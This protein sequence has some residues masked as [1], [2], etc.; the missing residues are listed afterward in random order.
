MQSF[1][2]E[3][4]PKGQFVICILLKDEVYFVYVRD[5]AR[6]EDRVTSQKIVLLKF[7]RVVRGRACKNCSSVLYF[8]CGYLLLSSIFFSNVTYC[9]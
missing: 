8:V 9:F 4:R 3:K 6:R 1:L 7:W 2:K 5:F